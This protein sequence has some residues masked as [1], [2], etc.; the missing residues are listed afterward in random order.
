M[1]LLTEFYQVTA[2]IC[3]RLS[4]FLYGL[5]FIP[6]AMPQAKMGQAFSLLIMDA[7]WISDNFLIRNEKGFQLCFS[8][9]DKCRFVVKQKA[10]SLK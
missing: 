5:A 3:F 6:A 1:E 10:E 2:P 7:V 9:P 4:A 8:I